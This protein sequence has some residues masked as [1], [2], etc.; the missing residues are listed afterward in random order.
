MQLATP[1]FTP[2]FQTTASKVAVFAALKA[3]QPLPEM[4]TVE[5]YLFCKAH[6]LV[7]YDHFIKYW[8]D[9]RSKQILHGILND[10]YPPLATNHALEDGYIG[11][12]VYV[13]V[14]KSVFGV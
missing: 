3:N 9:G 12:T 10:H 13:S 11:L 8:N 6:K 2:V 4:S 5:A 7:A 1:S 14:A